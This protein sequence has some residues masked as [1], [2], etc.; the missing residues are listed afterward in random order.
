MDA[1]EKE[2][3]K[4][5]KTQDPGR[6]RALADITALARANMG[7]KEFDDYMSKIKDN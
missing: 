1:Q 4:L 3:D 6:L 7:M 5:I 2:I